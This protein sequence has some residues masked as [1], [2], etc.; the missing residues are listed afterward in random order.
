MNMF[1]ECFLQR[2]HDACE[3]GKSCLG[4]A[5]W[6]SCGDGRVAARTRDP[7]SDHLNLH[8]PNIDRGLHNQATQPRRILSELR[9]IFR[10]IPDNRHS[11]CNPL[12]LWDPLEVSIHS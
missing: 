3:R 9:T 7:N 2:S 4:A 5:L 6:G 1:T 12:L 8:P 10:A 11:R